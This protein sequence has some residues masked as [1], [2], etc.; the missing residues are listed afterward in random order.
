MNSNISQ[1]QPLLNSTQYPSDLVDKVNSKADGPRPSSEPT[2][3]EIKAA[4]DYISMVMRDSM[5]MTDKMDW[6]WL[7]DMKTA[8]DLVGMTNRQLIIFLKKHDFD[9][10]YNKFN[11]Y[12]FLTAD[13]IKQVREM[14]IGRAP[15]KD[16]YTG[17]G[18][19][20][21]PKR[22]QATPQDPVRQSGPLV[23]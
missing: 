12:K 9:V 23:G 16:R 3:L 5:R 20:K 14:V 18:R 17:R 4:V 6:E 10:Y 11:N 2:R 19:K 1:L 13:Q 7:Y 22:S 21:V 15:A 8:G